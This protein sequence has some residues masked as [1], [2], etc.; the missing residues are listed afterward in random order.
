MCC[1]RGRAVCAGV[2]AVLALGACGGGGLSKEEL[3]S[4]ANTICEK[5]EADAEKLGDPG[6]PN[7]PEAAAAYLAKVAPIAER[8]LADL[9]ELEPAE[10]VKAD[11]DAFIAKEQEITTVLQTALR[12]ARARDPSGLADLQRIGTLADEVESAGAKVGAARAAIGLRG[13]GKDAGA[14]RRLPTSTPRA[15]SARG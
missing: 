9:K 15:R 2:L 3:G 11:W 6:N 5:A 1:G 10:D 13:P 8:Q 4:Q 7:D 12:K 14:Q